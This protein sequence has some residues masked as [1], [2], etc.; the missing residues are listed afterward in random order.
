[1]AAEFKTVDCACD[2][3]KQMCRE[4]PCWGTP[5]DARKM[6]EAGFG[7][8]LMLQYRESSTVLPPIEHTEMVVPAIRGKEGGM[9]PFFPW[10]ACALLDAEG[11]CRVHKI[12]PL[13]GR[14]VLHNQKQPDDLLFPIPEGYD[15]RDYIATLWQTPEAQRLV[16]EWK[17][18]FMNRKEN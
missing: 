10:G 14:V 17:E 11:M 1:M 15:L 16:E 13:E 3:C 4:T 5:D 8:S 2:R 6:I 18:K 9:T 7:A 12:K